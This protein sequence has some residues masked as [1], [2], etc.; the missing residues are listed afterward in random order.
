MSR[1][2]PAD[3]RYSSSSPEPAPRARP[4]RSFASRCN[5]DLALRQV[6]PVHL[7]CRVRPGAQL[8][9]H[10]HQP[11]PGHRVPHRP[12]LGRQLLQCRAH[13]H[14]HPLIGRVDDPGLAHTGPLIS[15]RIRPSPRPWSRS[16]AL[17]PAARHECLGYGINARFG[18]RPSASAR[19]DSCHSM[20][21]SVLIA[22]PRRTL[23]AVA[24]LPGGQPCGA[25]GPAAPS[26]TARAAAS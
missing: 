25:T 16:P 10:R 19:V 26:R 9:H 12:A 20:V 4:S 17:S 21:D 11:Q 5:E 23:A 8:E 24:D 18:A 14:P 7:A 6:G 2:S 22:G 3:S 1:G 15:C 13:E